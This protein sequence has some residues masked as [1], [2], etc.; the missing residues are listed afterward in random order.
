MS[1]VVSARSLSADQH[2]YGEW[3]RR[4]DLFSFMQARCGGWWIPG[5]QY[6]PGNLV[7]AM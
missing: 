6:A 5:G 3:Y 2:N 4:I 7:I 1:Q